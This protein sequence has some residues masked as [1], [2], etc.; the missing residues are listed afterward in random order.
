MRERVLTDRPLR[1]TILDGGQHV[2]QEVEATVG[3]FALQTVLPNEL[4]GELSNRSPA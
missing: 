4:G 1:L 3:E 2:G